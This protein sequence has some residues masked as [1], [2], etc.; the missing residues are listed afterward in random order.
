LKYKQHR[1]KWNDC[2]KCEL[3]NQ[4]GSVV[5]ARGKI[6]C[7]LL[8][9][10]EAPGQSEDVLGVPFVGPAGKLLDSIIDQATLT[11]RAE[12]SPGSG[13]PVPNENFPRIAFT[14]LVSC[15]PKGED[16]NKIQE[17]EKQHILEKN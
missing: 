13:K 2:E 1:E 17:P 7:D 8:F 10:G 12:Y 5:L 9:I 4:R 14:N 3:C 6:P 16:G 15:I 11:G